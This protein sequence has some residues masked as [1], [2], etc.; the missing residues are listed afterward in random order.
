MNSQHLL[1]LVGIGLVSFVLSYLGAA[2]GMV[3]GHLRLPLLVAVLDSPVSGASTNLAVSGLGAL[4]GSFPHLR[5]GRVSLSALALVGIPSA[6]GSIAGM[7]LFVKISRFWAH[8]T[9]GALL[10]M[11]GIRM[12]RRRSEQS[13]SE[14]LPDG[15]QIARDVLIGLLLGVL[16]AITGLMMN[17]L[18]LSLLVR[19]LEGNM[20]VAVGTNMAIGALTATVGVTTAWIMGSGF[21]LL[22]L[23]IVGP[24]TIAGSYLGAAL[25]AQLS[26]QTLQRMLGWMITILGFL[27]MLEGL[28]K[29]T[30]P[31][32][33]QPPP[34]TPAEARELEDETDEWFEEPDWAN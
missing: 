14:S 17:G 5:N 23:A 18:R 30:R 8:I 33:L 13:T 22:A 1:I 24:P 16:A 27:M 34:Q 29:E 3:L 10:L 19:R 2:V 25:T 7:L 4:A 6:L 28:W 12:L 31:R 21:N 11:L 20:Q 32:D 15:S 26:K 9:L